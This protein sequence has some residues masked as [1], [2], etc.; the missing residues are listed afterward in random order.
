MRVEINVDLDPL[1]IGEASARH[2]QAWAARSRSNGQMVQ[3][4]GNGKWETRRF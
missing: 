1:A 3:H 2:W 4:V